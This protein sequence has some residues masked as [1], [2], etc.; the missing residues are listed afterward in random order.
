[1]SGS[2]DIIKELKD[3]EEN[4][5]LRKRENKTIQD[6]NQNIARLTKVELTQQKLLDNIHT[7]VWFLIDDHTY[8]AVNNAHARF[9][10]C[11]KTDL[12]FK[13][14]YDVFPKE[15]VDVCREG[16]KKV[17]EVRKPIVSDEWVPHY[18]GEKR[19]IRIFK[20]PIFN[21]HGEV[22]YVVCSAEDI[23]EIKKAEDAAKDN[24]KNFRTFFETIDDLII[25]GSPNGKIVYTNP[26]VSRKL[27]FLPE[28]LKKMTLLEMHPPKYRNEAK[29]V[30]NE[31]FKGKRK[32]CPLPLQK[33]DGTFLPV[34]TRVW[35]GKWDKKECVFGISKDLSKQQA[36]LDKFHKLFDNNPALMAISSLT[37]SR[38]LEVN[39]AFLKK[40]GYSKEEVIGKTSEDL[41][42]F[43]ESDKQK[44]VA[45]TL[46]E[47]G[48]IRDIELDVRKKDG[49]IITG[50]FSGDIIDNQIEKNFLTVMTDI[51][52]QREA[53]KELHE[54][55]DVLQRY[56][57]VTIDREMKMIE[58]KK[59]NE[60]LKK[61][62]NKSW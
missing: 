4:G 30:L 33:K 21:H 42:L 34:E 11:E 9:N 51:T 18:S 7:Q 55:I 52:P 41:N 49:A 37:D 26:S 29:T 54:K 12:E 23:T 59:E 53:K 20:N 61:E 50:L 3:A 38:F 25:I 43:V 16:N 56:K 13:D 19:L 28:E 40:L 48:T 47:K 15:V 58:L 1:M 45:K 36:A 39:D 17:F 5:L 32:S 14:M 8:G 60:K 57:N 6:N 31:M 22:D 10:G 24:E 35:F 62:L 44:E 27:G 2:H 46:A